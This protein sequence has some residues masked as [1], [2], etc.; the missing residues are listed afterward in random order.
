[1]KDLDSR[2]WSRNVYSTF[3]VH[4]FYFPLIPFKVGG[5]TTQFFCALEDLFPS[6]STF[7]H[8]LPLSTVHTIFLFTQ[9]KGRSFCGLLPNSIHYNMLFKYYF[10]LFILS[11]QSPLSSSLCQPKCFLCRRLNGILCYIRNIRHQNRKFD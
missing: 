6:L 1:M 7:C 11:K 5:H 3:T 4:F 9:P 2:L 8:L 10:K